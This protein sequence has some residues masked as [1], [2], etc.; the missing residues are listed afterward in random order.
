MDPEKILSPATKLLRENKNIV[1]LL[2]LLLIIG[3][4][5]PFE[6]FM[7]KRVVIETYN[8]LRNQLKQPFVMGLVT[9][10]TYIVYF[11]NDKIMFTLLLFLIHQLSN[12]HPSIDQPLSDAITPSPKR[13]TP[14]AAPKQPPTPS[15][16]PKQPLAPA[17]AP[18]RPPTPAAA[19]KRPPTP[20]AA[21]KRPPTPGVTA[22][23]V[24]PTP[25]V[26]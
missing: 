23:G 5:F 3:Q 2:F 18:K 15:A 8:Y 11:T 1:N 20:A 24:P 26:R 22:S 4:L 12:N 7:E 25:P 16:A 10:L 21:P 14:A 17:A 9:L 13:P 19:P 6:L